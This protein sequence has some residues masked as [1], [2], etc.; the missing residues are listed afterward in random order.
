MPSI[1]AFV[2]ADIPSVSPG[3]MIYCEIKKCKDSQR[4]GHPGQQHGRRMPDLSFDTAL[5]I[6]TVLVSCFLPDVIQHI[7][8]FRASGVRSSQMEIK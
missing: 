3:R 7:R 2:M 8:S 1:Y 6:L 4:C 5:S